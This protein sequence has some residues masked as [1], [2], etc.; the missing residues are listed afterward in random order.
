MRQF[1]LR[2]R[3][4]LEGCVQAPLLEQCSLPPHSPPSFFLPDI[5]IT[6]STINAHA[7][8]YYTLVAQ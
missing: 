2:M 7:R 8:G 4:N 3:I 1:G 6:S 5:S